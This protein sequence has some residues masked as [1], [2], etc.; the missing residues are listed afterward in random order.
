MPPAVLALETR[1]DKRFC[2]ICGNL[3][4]CA[5]LA[6]RPYWGGSCQGFRTLG[7]VCET[8]AAASRLI[9]LMPG[10]DDGVIGCEK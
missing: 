1:G 10:N 7:V 2:E 3:L 9:D 4:R 6:I 8:L 5:A